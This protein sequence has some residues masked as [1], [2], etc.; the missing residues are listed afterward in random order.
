MSPESRDRK[1]SNTRTK[2]RL[3]KLK[4]LSS[5]NTASILPVVVGHRKEHWDQ[6]RVGQKMRPHLPS[7]L[8]ACSLKHWSSSQDRV[9]F[10][11]PLSTRLSWLWQVKCSKPHVPNSRST[12]STAGEAYRNGRYGCFPGPLL[13]PPRQNHWAA[14][15]E[16]CTATQKHLI[17]HR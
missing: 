8:T 1:P 16:C 4:V 12:S 13:S 11:E 3:T 9:P 14:E 2:I 15:K 5:R 17:R 7:A 10:S 6:V